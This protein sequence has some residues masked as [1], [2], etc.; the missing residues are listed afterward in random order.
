MILPQQDIGRLNRIHGINAATAA[1]QR[2]L[3]KA[4]HAGFIVHD[5]N[6]AFL[7]AAKCFDEGFFRMINWGCSAQLNSMRG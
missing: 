4:A 6:G 1:D 3:Q 2:A 7:P 5:Q